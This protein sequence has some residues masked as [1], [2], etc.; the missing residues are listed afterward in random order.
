MA[1][2]NSGPQPSAASHQIPPQYRKL[3]WDTVGNYAFG[4]HVDFKQVKR[5]IVLAGVTRQDFGR[6]VKWQEEINQYFL[7][8]RTRNARA[9]ASKVQGK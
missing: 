8:S 2:N 5:V 3:Y 6:D 7:Q 9:F 4:K 1:T